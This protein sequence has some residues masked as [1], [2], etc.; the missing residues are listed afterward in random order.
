M[1]QNPEKDEK[2][3]SQTG[4]EI[5]LSFSKSKFWSSQGLSPSHYLSS[6]TH[7]HL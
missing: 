7:R 6:H 3:I 4:S 2:S 5:P 1:N